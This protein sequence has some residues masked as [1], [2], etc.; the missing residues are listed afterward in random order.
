MAPAEV[1]APAGAGLC[2][3]AMDGPIVVATLYPPLKNAALAARRGLRRSGLRIESLAIRV[4][5]SSGMAYGA[6]GH[7][8]P[9]GSFVLTAAA[10]PP[11]LTPHG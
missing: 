6:V 5:D 10:L 7:F 8:D 2:S 3:L 1:D 4:T 11:E 9:T